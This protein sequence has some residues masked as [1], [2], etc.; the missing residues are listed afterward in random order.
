MQVLQEVVCDV[1]ATLD[2]LNDA[3]TEGALIEKPA[4]EI[5]G[6]RFEHGDL[7]TQRVVGCLQSCLDIPVGSVERGDG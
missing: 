3:L 6:Y 7:L 4:D 5:M 1:G 2:R